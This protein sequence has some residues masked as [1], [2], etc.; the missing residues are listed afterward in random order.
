MNCC[1]KGP[2]DGSE[3]D[4][5]HAGADGPSGPTGLMAPR[6]SPGEPGVRGPTGRSG[7]NGISGLPAP[8]WIPERDAAPGK[9]GPAGRDGSDGFAGDQGPPG[10]EG[11]VG[12]PG[13]PG[14]DGYPGPAG[15]PGL[16]GLDGSPGPCGGDGAIGLPGPSGS[17]PIDDELAQKDRVKADMRQ[18][19]KRFVEKK[20][21]I[22]R[23]T[24]MAE[25]YV[26]LG[27]NGRSFCR[28]KNCGAPDIEPPP[29]E[30][31]ANCK[32]AASMVVVTDNSKS[33]TDNYEMH[34]D[35]VE[36]AHEFVESWYNKTAESEANHE[37][38]AL[39]CRFSNR[40]QVWSILFCTIMYVSKFDFCSG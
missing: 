13:E 7:P 39:F 38:N 26:G 2:E 6:G 8:Q 17:S 24:G 18:R 19:M 4:A 31:C 22:D 27:N 1:Q 35:L 29:V 3:G 34:D 32:K 14:P 33:V 28:C 12:Y 37:S 20:E 9:A 5:G 21:N 23:I 36:V 10:Q 16:K 15:T 30:D 25:R 40:L 11:S